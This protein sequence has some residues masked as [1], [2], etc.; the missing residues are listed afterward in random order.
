VISGLQRHLIPVLKNSFDKRHS[1]WRILTDLMK[2]CKS[3]GH[4]LDHSHM[5]EIPFFLSLDFATRSKESISF[6]EKA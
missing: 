1:P 3:G 2:L 4:A 5:N 6:S